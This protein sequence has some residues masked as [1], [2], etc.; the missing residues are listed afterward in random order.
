[1]AYKILESHLPICIVNHCVVPYL[2]LS[3]D[4]I[5]K[6]H[7]N[8]QRQLH[9][10]YLN[11]GGF[12]KQV[13]ESECLTHEILKYKLYKYNKVFDAMDRLIVF[14]Q[15]MRELSELRNDGEE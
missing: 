10:V 15:T 8:L 3:D 9:C 12:S 7:C 5:K 6:N 14:A 13:D 1:M 4:E 2:I 11:A